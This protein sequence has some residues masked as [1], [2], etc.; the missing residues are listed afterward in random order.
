[1]ANLMKNIVLVMKRT[2]RIF[3]VLMAVMLASVMMLTGCGEDDDDGGSRKKKPTEPPTGSGTLKQG[4]KL[5]EALGIG[6]EQPTTV[7]LT[8]KNSDGGTTT[9]TK[10]ARSSPGRLSRRVSTEA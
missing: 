1:M 3:A 10:R 9:R 5:T 2:K 8:G 6:S 7:T 4:K